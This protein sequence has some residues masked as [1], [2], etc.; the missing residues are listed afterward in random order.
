V[1]VYGSGAQ[2]RDYIYVGDVVEA[3]LAA[4]RLGQPGMWNIGTG[5]E[6]SVIDLISLIGQSAGRSPSPR[7]APPRSGELQRS[8]LDVTRAASDLGWKS[9]VQ[10]ASGI[11]R[12]YRWVQAGEPDRAR[13]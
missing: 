6:T 2:T 13:R 8:A 9:S 3:F 1:T 4:A 11:G 5:L 7:F 12:V 10:L